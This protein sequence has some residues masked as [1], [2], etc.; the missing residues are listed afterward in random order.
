MAI[1]R[2]Y[3]A[4]LIVGML[5]YWTSILSAVGDSG[6]WPQWRGPQRDGSVNAGSWPDSLQSSTLKQRW[7][8]DVPPS[9]S[10]PIVSND[11]VF[12]TYTRDEK[13]EGVCALDR[14]SGTQVWKAEWEGTMQ[15]AAVSAEHG[16]LDPRDARL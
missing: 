7:R 16:E 11:K 10:G 14:E 9:Y 8:V 4:A 3:A 12:V 6:T 1:A 13:F 15:V 2:R 5:F